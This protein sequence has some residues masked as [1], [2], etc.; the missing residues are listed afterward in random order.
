MRLVDC[1]LNDYEQITSLLKDRPKHHGM[2]FK[3]PEGTEAHSSKDGVVVRVDWNE[4]NNGHCVE[5]QY[6]DGVLA[7]FLHLSKTSVTAG[8]KITK[9]TVVGLTGNTGHSTAPHLH[10]ELNQ[11][12]KVIDPVDYQG[13]ERRTLP[14]ANKAAFDAERARLDAILATQT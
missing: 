10:Y 13:T 9:G 6:P 12:G 7:R 8:Q 5:V 14:L 4:F 11:N 3:V 1:P 2:D